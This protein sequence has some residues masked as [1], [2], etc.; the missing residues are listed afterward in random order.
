TTI[1][2]NNNHNL[3]EVLTTAIETTTIPPLQEVL[4]TTMVEEAIPVHPEAME[5]E[6]VVPHIVEDKIRN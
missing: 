6:E 5:A 2:T 4:T 3:Q 1:A